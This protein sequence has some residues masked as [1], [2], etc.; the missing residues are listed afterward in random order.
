MEIHS[1]LFFSVQTQYLMVWSTTAPR[2]I[3]GPSDTST[4]IKRK[5]SVS[6]NFHW[7]FLS[8]LLLAQIQCTYTHSC[9]PKAELAN[10]LK[11]RLLCK[12]RTQLTCRIDGQ[13]FIKVYLITMTT[14]K[15]NAREQVSLS[16]SLS[17]SH[18]HTHTHIHTHSLSLSVSKGVQ[19]IKLGWTV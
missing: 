13:N 11:V 5:I 9:T 7:I 3:V 2:N 1:L 8:W 6:K 17:L 18:T 10:E 15:L 19:I 14:F 12:G 16:L 4:A